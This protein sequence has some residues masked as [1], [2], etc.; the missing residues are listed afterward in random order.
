MCAFQDMESLKLWIALAPQQL[1]ELNKG[2]EVFPDAYSGRFGLRL[3]PAEAV[4]RAQ[5]FMDWTPDGLKDKLNLFDISVSYEIFLTLCC[6]LCT[7]L[8][9]SRGVLLC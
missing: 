9:L 6:V 7:L 1:E 2:N 4:D 5:Y 8:A 3:G